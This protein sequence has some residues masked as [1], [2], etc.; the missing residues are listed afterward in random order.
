MT[1]GT[2]V[3]NSGW[4]VGTMIGR[5]VSETMADDHQTLLHCPSNGSPRLPEG[6]GGRTVW[7]SVK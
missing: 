5:T 7:R 1:V 6:S 3:E 4:I 2:S